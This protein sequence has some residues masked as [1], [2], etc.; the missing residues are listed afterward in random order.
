MD[1]Q[2][3]RR[4]L[5]IRDA[6]RDRVVVDLEFSPPR[7]LN[8][9]RGRLL[10][11]GVEIIVQESY[12]YISNN[13]TFMRNNQAQGGVLGLYVGASLCRLRDAAAVQVPAPNRAFKSRAEVD[14]ALRDKLSGGSSRESGAG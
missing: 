12:L 8:L 9:K 11:N 3:V 13:D 1:V 7:G 6:H 5:I 2:F 14:K 4:S 10:A